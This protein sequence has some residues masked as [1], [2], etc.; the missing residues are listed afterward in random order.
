MR[1]IIH[2]QHFRTQPLTT[3]YAL[4]L[5][6]VLQEISRGRNGS[7]SRLAWQGMW[8]PIALRARMCVVCAGTGTWVLPGLSHTHSNLLLVQAPPLPAAPLDGSWAVA[9]VTLWND[10]TAPNNGL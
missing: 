10:L 9:L 3:P 2:I 4:N 7:V 5:E 1:H 6:V 8:W